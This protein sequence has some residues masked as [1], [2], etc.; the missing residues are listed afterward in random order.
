MSIPAR[1]LEQQYR[2]AY[3]HSI[4][5]AWL[6]CAILLC[7]IPLVIGK[8]TGASILRNQVGSIVE[9]RQPSASPQNTPGAKTRR[10]RQKSVEFKLLGASD[11]VGPENAVVDMYFIALSEG[12]QAQPK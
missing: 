5:A 1:Q 8:M 6:A 10:C 12:T 11:R 2:R 7:S 4:V 9:S 3:R